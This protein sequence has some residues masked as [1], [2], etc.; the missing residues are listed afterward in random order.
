MPV[1]LLWNG[2]IGTYVKATTE[3]QSD[4]GDPNNNG[5]RIDAPQLRARVVGEGGNLG[6]TQLARIEYSLNGGR[7]NTD[8]I[9]NS[10]GVDMSDHE[11][12]IKILLSPAVR[13]GKISSSER[14]RFLVEMT[15][16]VSRLVL[17]NNYSQALCLSLAEHLGEDGA[18]TLESLQH[19]LSAQGRLKPNVEFLPSS[20]ALEQRRR[21]GQGYSRPEMAIMLAYAKMDLRKSLLASNLLAE[22]ALERHLFGYFPNLLR[23]DFPDE[24]RTHQLRREIIATRLTNLIIDRLGIAFMRGVEEDT[25]G[26]PNE[27]LSAVLVT[28]EILELDKLFDRLFALDEAIPAP[29]QYRSMAALNAAAKGIVH[30][31]ILSGEGED[32]FS[33]LVAKYREP[34][35]TLR[36]R[37]DQFLPAASER[38]RFLSHRQENLA[39]GY[40]EDLATEIAASD[41]WASCMG[42]ADISARTS[43]EL[44]RAA[45]RFYA[46]GDLFSLGWIRDQL[47]SFQAGSRWEA[48][49]LNGIVAD[50]RQL[51]RQFTV[52][53]FQWGDDRDWKKGL[54]KSEA[55]LVNRVNATIAQFKEQNT[56]DLSAGSVLARL[57]MQ[58][59]R[60][61][62]DGQV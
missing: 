45:R 35:R 60:R 57:L 24:V 37:I 54:L 36:S 21:G 34:L 3:S 49:A 33:S 4:V 25:Q 38:R 30:W 23:S 22:S 32:D 10:G 40:P 41:Y 20:R 46:I 17:A 55:V 61:L 26:Q 42:V 6:L 29:A 31:L 28:Q 7:I 52:V 62:E 5:V 8:A 27:V 19:H 2:G 47:R 16:E 9:D 44:D 59:L 14:N 48:V 11:V 18:N 56:V 43:V 12:N 15:D 39:D 1:D 53:S 58:L 13:A 50:L 51:Q